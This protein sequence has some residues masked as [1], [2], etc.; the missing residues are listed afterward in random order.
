MKERA[1][2]KYKVILVGDVRVGKTTLVNRFV[3]K[4][5]NAEYLATIGVQI[6]TKWIKQ[7][8]KTILL[9]IWDIAGQTAFRQFRKRFFADS[10]GA[11]L[12][13]DLTVPESLTNL[14]ISWLKDIEE[15]TGT[16]P[17]VLIGN[18]LDLVDARKIRDNEIEAFL[19]HHSN[20]GT[21]LITSALTGFNVEVAFQELVSLIEPELKKD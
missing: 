13:F 14:H 19:S 16:I 3:N 17:C 18:K 1:D 15:I 6:Y 11:F 21:N 5:F 7:D 10:R 20:I 9:Q 2:F 12:V 8:Q 4:T